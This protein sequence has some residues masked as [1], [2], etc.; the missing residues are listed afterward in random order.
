MA[1]KVL[2]KLKIAEK[3]RFDAS[4]KLQIFKFYIYEYISRL[5]KHRGV[6]IA[7]TIYLS[8]TIY[9]SWSNYPDRNF[10]EGI[11]VEMN[12]VAIDIIL[13]SFIVRY[14]SQKSIQKDTLKDLNIKLENLKRDSIDSKICSEE[15]CRVTT[16]ITRH[17]KCSSISFDK[18]K[19]KDLSFLR[20]NLSLSTF[21]Q[22]ELS[23]ILFRQTIL[24]KTE[25]QF[26]ELDNCIFDN[27][28]LI[29]ARFEKSIINNTKFH[30]EDLR[31]ADFYGAQ[32]F[33]VDFGSSNIEG[34]NFS[35]ADLHAVNFEKT[36]GFHSSILKKATYDPNQVSF[37]KITES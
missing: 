28:N 23:H 3:Y 16:K 5:N 24:R 22:S 32:L 21:I 10:V 31:N 15:L 9:S 18:I 20:L 27:S 30:K 4:V 7:F 13:F 29:Q 17:C 34:I 11:L 1:N 36:K 14:F 25:F 33:N 6:V 35:G 26:S 2:S 37:P 12:G 8:I 19:L